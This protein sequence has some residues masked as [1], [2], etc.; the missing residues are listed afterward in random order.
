MKIVGEDLLNKAQ[1]P[2]KKV[3]P[4]AAQKKTPPGDGGVE[5]NRPK[6]FR[7]IRGVYGAVLRCINRGDYLSKKRAAEAAPRAACGLHQAV[8]AA[9]SLTASSAAL[10]E[11]P[12]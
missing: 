11:M 8:A 1:R 5:V 3:A 2:T 12:S 9:L 7:A 10:A 4:K 6:G